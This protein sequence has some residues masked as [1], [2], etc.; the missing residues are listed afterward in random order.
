MKLPLARCAGHSR[1]PA[2][3]S[4]TTAAPANDQGALHLGEL[5]GPAQVCRDVGDASLKTRGS[6]RAAIYLRQRE[7][8]RFR[9]AVLAVRPVFANL[10]GQRR[11]LVPRAGD[12]NTLISR[13]ILGCD[14]VHSLYLPVYMLAGT[15]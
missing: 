8:L 1:C 6:H 9:P 15:P 12:D 2:T 13:Y 7:Q 5:V 4:S 10:A 14:G 3:L 11:V